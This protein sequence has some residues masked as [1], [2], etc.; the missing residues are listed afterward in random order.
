MKTKF[1]LGADPELFLIN[2]N[3]NPKSAIGIISGTKENPFN[4]SNKGHSVQVD[5]VL[6]EFNIP[7][8]KN[9]TEMFSNINFV[10]DW[11]Y[12]NIPRDCSLSFDSSFIFDD[13][14]IEDD[15]AKE[16]GCDPDLDAWRET[17]NDA[18]CSTT[19][20]RTAGGHIHVS[21]DDYNMD[22]SL[23]LVKALD[24]FLGVPSILIDRDVRRRE[25]YG[26]AGCFRF[27]DYSDGS[28]GFEYRSLSNF[29]IRSENNIEMIYTQ[30]E[31]AFDYIDSGNIINKDSS[32]ASDIV[33]CINTGDEKLAMK[34]IK[35]YN[36]I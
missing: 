32:L 11:F 36:L 1:I 13:K 17:V 27:K 24:L 3:G 16:F 30:I 5:N 2:S 20:L 15:A 23:E 14:E 25:L 4:I 12:N 22:K 35:K 10:I 33:K 34:L 18:P 7:P 6:L 28:G 8:S 19:N 31:K 29:W 26:K 9:P 21:Y